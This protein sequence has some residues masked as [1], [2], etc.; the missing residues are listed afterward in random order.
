MFSVW[1]I[2]YLWQL[3]VSLQVTF[4]SQRTIAIANFTFN[5]V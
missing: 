3:T 4:K 1:V 2:L 5:G